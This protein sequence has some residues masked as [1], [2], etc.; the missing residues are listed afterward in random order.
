MPWISKSWQ[1]L[2]DRICRSLG[3]QGRVSSS[4]YLGNRNRREAKSLGRLHT[5]GLAGPGVASPFSDDSI[6]FLDSSLSGSWESF[7]EHHKLC[8]PWHKLAAL[9]TL[10]GSVRE[11]YGRSG[12]FFRA[13]HWL[14]ACDQQ[15][16]LGIQET[17]NRSR[18]GISLII[19]MPRSCPIL[20]AHCEAD[21]YIT[22][23]TSPT[24]S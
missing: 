23:H 18:D 19:P 3:R 4:S 21:L 9:V 6:T 24:I 22:R 13:L 11:S 12:L 20:G 7:S 10:T 17:R 16:P 15:L 8:K 2:Q 5:G 1:P 14:E